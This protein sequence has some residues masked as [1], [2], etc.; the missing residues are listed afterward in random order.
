M[1]NAKSKKTKTTN[2]KKAK[3]TRRHN[4]TTIITTDKKTYDY[5]CKMKNGAKITIEGVNDIVSSA[6]GSKDDTHHYLRRVALIR[7]QIAGGFFKASVRYL[8]G[9]EVA[10]V[11]CGVSCGH[12]DSCTFRVK[13]TR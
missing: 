11:L 3:N 9:F 7:R 8:K 12:D 10:C 6:R 4:K 1:N 5:V 13:I 2:I